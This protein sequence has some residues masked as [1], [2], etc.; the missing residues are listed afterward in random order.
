MQSGINKVHEAGL[1]RAAGVAT[2]SHL[3]SHTLETH[4]GGSEFGLAADDLERVSLDVN[5]PLTV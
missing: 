3:A 2:K 4:L 5:L 1:G